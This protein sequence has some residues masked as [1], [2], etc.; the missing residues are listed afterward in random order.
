MRYGNLRSHHFNIFAIS[1]VEIINYLPE[2]CDRGLL[3]G[4]D[5]LEDAA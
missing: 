3:A 1:E 4:V 2:L 5:E